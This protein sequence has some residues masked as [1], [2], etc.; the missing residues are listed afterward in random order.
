MTQW[1]K[2]LDKQQ[3]MATRIQLVSAGLTRRALERE[4][5]DGRLR[6]AAQG[7]YV[8]RTPPSRGRHL[9]SGGRV[10]AGFVAEVRAA[11][12]RLHGNAWAARLTAAV[13]WGFDLAE[14]PVL[15][16]LNVPHGHRVRLGDDVRWKQSRQRNA[17]LVVPVLG[18]DP[19]AVTSAVDT[20]LDCAQVLPLAQAVVV[21]DSAMRRGAC[22]RAQLRRAISA[23]RGPFCGRLWR[24]LR[25]CDPDSGSVL[26]SLLRVLLCVAGLAPTTTQYR[27][28]DKGAL[29]GRA[30]FAWLVARLLVETDGRR[31]HDPDDVRDADRR[32]D[33]GFARL[34]WRVLRFT[35]AE[36]VHQPEQVVAAVRAALAW[37]DSPGCVHPALDGTSE[38]PEV[39][40]V[41]VIPSRTQPGWG[42]GSAPAAAASSHAPEPL[43]RPV[44]SRGSG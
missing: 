35:W 44:R 12:L 40:T 13:M 25:W 29:I 26:E 9:L 27:V 1:Q 43:S 22:T 20:V 33:N 5:D 41:P 38:T 6:R 3:G 18:C 16:D 14:E 36:V 24:V 17:E 39:T 15:I 42:S 8:D 30:D 21:A 19:I 11:V 23:R 2:L 31:W 28:V 34:G 10:D 4:L 32:R 7:L 37:Q